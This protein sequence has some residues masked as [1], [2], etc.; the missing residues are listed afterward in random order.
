MT[1]FFDTVQE[2]QGVLCVPFDSS[3]II[4]GLLYIIRWE[5]LKNAYMAVVG[6]PLDVF[7]ILTLQS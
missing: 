1:C 3:F 2:T 7:I 5:K 4:S 6:V